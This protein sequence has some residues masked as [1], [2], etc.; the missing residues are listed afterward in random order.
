[1]EKL[2]EEIGFRIRQA[3]R[4]SG[5]K[6][7]REAAELFAVSEGTWGNWERG[8]AFPGPEELLSIAEKFGVT[9]DYLFTGQYATFPTLG[10]TVREHQT[11]WGRLETPPTDIEVRIIG[12]LRRIGPKERQHLINL[13]T[14]AYY[15]EVEGIKAKE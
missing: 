6:N 2:R 1:M 4:N 13:I 10:H 11:E 9:F 8:D 14:N 12:M 3:R 5:L 15:D 7:I